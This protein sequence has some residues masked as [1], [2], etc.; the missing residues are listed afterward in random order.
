MNV[1]G[2]APG[3]DD[4]VELDHTLGV[5]DLFKDPLD[6]LVLLRDLGRAVGGAG[7]GVVLR[8]GVVVEVDVF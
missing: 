3:E 6:L 2:L 4:L 8:L 5:H 1:T 7:G